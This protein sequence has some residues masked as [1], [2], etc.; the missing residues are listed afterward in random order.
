MKIGL[1]GLLTM[2]IAAGSLLAGC[3]EVQ[4]IEDP[5]VTE[6]SQ[7]ETQETPG[8]E[9]ETLEEGAFPGMLAYDFILEDFEGNFVR[10]SDY[11]GKSVMLFFWASWC[12]YCGEQMRVMSGMHPDLDPDRHVILGINL[13]EAEKDYE[14]ALMKIQENQAG[15]INLIDAES[16]VSLKYGAR[17]I[18]LSVFIDP[19]GV[20]TASIVG[21]LEES[22]IMVQFM[23]AN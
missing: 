23:A 8:A 1:I 10:L 6:T 3:G 12:P 2:A 14:D 4:N 18:P 20:I 16:E 7:E 19:E 22:Q 13:M 5:P 9:E 21:P 11:R 15:F 17:T